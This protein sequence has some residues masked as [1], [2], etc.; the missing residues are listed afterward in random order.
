M[1]NFLKASLKFLSLKLFFLFFWVLN[2]IF[3]TNA[4]LLAVDEE[5]EEYKQVKKETV[6]I[7]DEIMKLKK[8]LNLDYSDYS[9]YKKELDKSGKI[10][11]AAK[12]FDYPANPQIDEGGEKISPADEKSKDYESLRK[13]IE[14]LKKQLNLDY[15]DYDKFKKNPNANCENTI[16]IFD[17]PPAAE[18][19]PLPDSN[20]FD[21]GNLV[22]NVSADKELGERESL[23]FFA[24]G[25]FELDGESKEK[26]KK[27][28]LL[29][30]EN[31]SKVTI[32]GYTDLTASKEVNK[33]L[34]IKRAVAVYNELIANGAPEE[35]LKY[36]GRY[37][38]DPVGDETTEDGRSQN[39][40]VDALKGDRDFIDN[41]NVN[42]IME[43]KNGEKTVREVVARFKVN[44]YELNDENKAMVKQYA[45]K[46][47]GKNKDL[48]IE[49]H[50]DITGSLRYNKELSLKRAR[51]VYH[52]LVRDG[53]DVKKL[54][55]VGKFT[56]N[57][58]GDNDTEEG[59]K[60]NR[61]AIVVEKISK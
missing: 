47:I 17:A 28:A 7:K 42:I 4:S 2:V 49:G 50:T 46:T 58:I 25:S 30:K 20:S 55:Y 39:R 41:S 40:R 24:P 21:R 36:A 8:E 16:V 15:S 52:E 13:E 11:A 3:F 54:E 45:Q 34:S 59:R 18:Q 53:L 38:L 37:Y 27:Y 5:Y 35:N 43:T 12:S 31:P 32:V 56:L 48:I 23:A 22:K 29:L 33:G 1:F 9:E 14:E 44:E 26:I 6:K 19:K 51:N 60:A 61:N 57:P 10:L